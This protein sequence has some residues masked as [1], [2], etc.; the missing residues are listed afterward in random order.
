MT[1]SEAFTLHGPDVETIAQA[2]GIQ[3]HEA[4]KLINEEM[5]R[6]FAAKSREKLLEQNR[7][8][9]RRARDERRE[10]RRRHA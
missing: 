4:D 3:P 1:F 6:K 10:I 8:R 5:D 2:M 7:A 9:Y